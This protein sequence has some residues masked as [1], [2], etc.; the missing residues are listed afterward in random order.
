MHTAALRAFE[1]I[2]SGVEQLPNSVWTYCLGMLRCG[3]IQI[4]KVQ[5]E[6]TNTSISKYKCCCLIKVVHHCIQ[7]RPGTKFDEDYYPCKICKFMR[8]N[9]SKQILSLLRFSELILWQNYCTLQQKDF[10]RTLW[11]PFP[12]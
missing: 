3:Y 2:K 9:R 12:S 5:N 6:P 11:S 10:G 4:N 8:E 7:S 1:H